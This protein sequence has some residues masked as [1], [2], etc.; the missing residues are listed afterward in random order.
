MALMFP[1]A[2]VAF[3]TPEAADDQLDLTRGHGPEQLRG[4]IGVS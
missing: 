2:Q 4:P 1:I 3:V